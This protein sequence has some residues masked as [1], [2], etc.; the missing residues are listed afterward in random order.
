MEQI[1]YVTMAA[2]GPGNPRNDTASVAELPDGPLM[3][4]WHKYSDSEEK[5]SDFGVARIYAKTSADGG[6]TW[7]DERMLVDVA[8]G[9]VNVQA[10]ALCLLPSGEL[11]LICLRAH[12]RDSTSM[13][14]LRSRDSG[15]S[16]EQMGTIWERSQ[17]QWL[18]GG[19]SSLLLLS[20]G[21]LLVPFHGGQG[22]QHSQHNTIRCFISDDL[23]ASWRP[24]QAGIDLPMRGAMEASVAEL[25]DGTLAMSI[26]TQLG[27]PFLS[28]SH[29]GGETWS[30]AQTTGL[31]GGE[32]CTCLRRIPGTDDLVIFWNNSLYDPSH[33]HYGE[34]TPLS[35]ALSRDAGESWHKLG[36][37]DNGD[38]EF[39]NLG[40]TFTS[41]GGAILTYMATRPAF[42][43]KRMHLEAAL[44]PL[45]WFPA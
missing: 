39:T 18:Q 27:S 8:P 36:D 9:D 25:A 43:R 40:C 31:T 28:Y 15:R 35:A 1:Q 16:F 29:D 41:Q 19:A 21:R 45:E 44:I 11:L 34:R 38:A 5:G 26:R 30:P 33:H 10:P 17:G 12:A 3:V 14:L 23:G 2:A 7:A 13:L 37:I 24:S 32:S 22:G 20:G 6:V 4:V 42:D